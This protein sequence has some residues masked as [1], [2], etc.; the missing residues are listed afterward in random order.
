MAR[1]FK[2]VS[3][4]TKSIGNN[5][6]IRSYNAAPME[7]MQGFFQHIRRNR[8]KLLNSNRTA[9]DLCLSIARNDGS[10]EFPDRI[11]ALLT[12][13]SIDE[14]NYAASSAYALL[15]GDQR[16]KEL[17]AYFTPPAL[18]SAALEAGREYLTAH[19]SPR[20]LD[21]ACG[22]GSFLAP[23]ARLLVQARTRKGVASRDNCSQVLKLIKGIE[24]D[25]GLAMLAEGLL[26]HTL[27]QEFSYVGSG[28]GCVVE[29]ADA[30]SVEMRHQYD[31]V[32]G[33][34]P[35]GKVRSKV[36]KDY[37]TKAGL[38]NLGGH[39]NLYSLF[40]L[41]SLDW[42]KP[43]GG[44]V[45]VLPPSFVAGPYFSGLRQELMYR[46]EVR[47]IDL[48]AQRENLFLGAVQDICLLSLK[49]RKE[50][51]RRASDLTHTY[52][53]GFIDA[54]GARHDCGT[55]NAKGD[56]EPWTLPVAR[57]VFALGEK[58]PGRRSGSGR[59]FVL[60]D[61]GYRL[62]VGKVVPTRER[63]LLH[64]TREK[65]D[66]PLIWASSIRPDGSFDFEA[67][68]K[69]ANAQWYAAPNCTGSYIT[70]RPSVVVQRTSNRDQ[71]RI[72]NAAAVPKKFREKHPKGYAAENHV[73]VL[74]SLS[75]RPEVGISTVAKLINSAIVN[76][77]FSAVS[78][79]F[80]VSA[81]LLQRLAL[82]DPRLVQG[83]RAKDFEHGLRR[84]YTGMEEVLA[85]LDMASGSHNAVDQTRDLRRSATVDENTRF[86][87]RPA[88]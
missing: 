48:H 65:G 44:L 51:A 77:R 36:S 21:P 59:A 58:K 78:G 4:E 25:P 8:T 63:D 29:R 47:R 31:L 85:P 76:E 6:V 56:G 24:I 17:S 18:A 49:V 52:Q 16:R 60:A 72:L 64:L 13:A 74:E 83:L 22:G 34:P 9:V 19:S 79:S 35:F 87:R 43:G 84:L 5:A 68:K 39:T 50:P 12:Q 41:R 37:L 23:V 66:L 10:I 15:I 88:A 1:A 11:G 20:V 67:S 33:N 3:D 62:R 46:A 14:R 40:L 71:K 57:R 70:T 69:L 75:N 86:K 53:L 80:S 28:N 42:V 2:K 30:L 61:Y 32:I 54:Q 73:I 81:K 38:A 45:F 27:A 26:A 7:E 82:P 55:G